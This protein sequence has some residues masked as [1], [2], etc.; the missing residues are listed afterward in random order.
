[1]LARD[2][3]RVMEAVVPCPG[4]GLEISMVPPFAP[5]NVDAIQKPRPDPG[6]AA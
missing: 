2:P 6:I 3:G 5:T 1:M 4:P